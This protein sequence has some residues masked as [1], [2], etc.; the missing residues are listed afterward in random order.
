LAGSLGLTAILIFAALFWQAG[1]MN[2]CLT[3]LIVAGTIAGFLKFNF[4]KATIFMGDNGST[5]IG[6]L[7]A[8][9]FIKFLNFDYYQSEN[10]SAL[11]TAISIVFIPVFDLIRVF[12]MRIINKKGPMSP[13]K[14]HLHHHLLNMGKSHV[15]VCCFILIMHFLA[16]AIGHYF[17]QRFSLTLSLLL[18]VLIEVVIVVLI[19]CSL[20][21][22]SIKK[23]E[24][25]RHTIG[26][27]E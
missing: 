8:V 22:T 6:F 27:W 19:L 21:L 14:T 23:M 25:T 24:S 7:I 3:S 9:F 2:W 15:W 11:L 16:F 4:G 20:E 26:L 5:F 10:S 13:D 17:L 12:L 18:T 1:L